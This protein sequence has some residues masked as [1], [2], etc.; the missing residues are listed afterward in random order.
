MC[1][2]ERRQREELEQ[3]SERERERERE[4]ASSRDT[5]KRLALAI[6]AST[7]LDYPTFFSLCC[8]VSQVVCAAR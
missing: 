1:V 8:T 3:E 6:Q 2:R 7:L 4:R 5:G